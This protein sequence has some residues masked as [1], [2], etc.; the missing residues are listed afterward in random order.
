MCTSVIS[1]ES[2]ILWKE[3]LT[4]DKPYISFMVGKSGGGSGGGGGGGAGLLQ[5]VSKKERFITVKI[6]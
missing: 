1:S 5:S 6:K 2:P 4:Y 3:F